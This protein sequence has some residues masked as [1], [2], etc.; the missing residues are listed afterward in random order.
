MYPLKENFEVFMC[1]K[2]F[3]AKVGTLHLDR[4]GEYM[5]KDFDA[6]SG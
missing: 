3:V 2:Q 6:F 4:E 1:F 5:S